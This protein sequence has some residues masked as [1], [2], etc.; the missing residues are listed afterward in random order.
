MILL[1]VR[2]EYV[3]NI[4]NGKKK[5]EFRRKIFR[6]NVSHVIIYSTRPMKKIV[7]YFEVGEIIEDSPKVLWKNYKKYSGMKKSDFFSYFN[8]CNIGYAIKIKNFLEY[9]KYK[10]L[11][12]IGN[13]IRPPQSYAY[14]DD[15]ILNLYLSNI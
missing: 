15:T 9:D 12:F 2:P 8:G 11:N 3:K 14:I 1:S 4:I 10:E 5:Y 6:K 13:N 7:G